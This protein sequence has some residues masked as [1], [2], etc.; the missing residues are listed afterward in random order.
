[1][2]ML[3]R[4]AGW[5]YLGTQIVGSIGLLGL[6]LVVGGT[7]IYRWFG[8]TFQGSYE[9]A[10]TF[11]ILTITMAIFMATVQQAHVDVR[12]I[13]DRF[14]HGVRRALR[15]V[16]GLMAVAFWATVTWSAYRMALSLTGRGEI[17]DVL[18]INIVPFRWVTVVGLG[19]VTLMLAWYTW[20]WIAGHATDEAGHHGASDPE[21]R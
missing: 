9:V 8:G 4:L 6:M 10:E 20:R 21:D 3:R 18:R 11:T 12:L 5:V 2:H 16:L 15:I 14:S 1:M 19:A 13:Y 17:T 7:V